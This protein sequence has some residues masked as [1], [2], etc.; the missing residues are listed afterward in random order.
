MKSDD[1]HTSLRAV[2]RE[3]W[4]I[5]PTPWRCE[6]VAV[7]A[8]FSLEKFSRIRMGLLPMRMEDKWFV[9][10]E[11]PWLHLHRSWTGFHAVKARFEKAP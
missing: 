3:D 8:V 10:Y 7:D 4:K 11:D 9:F 2:R 1:L 5:A 6:A